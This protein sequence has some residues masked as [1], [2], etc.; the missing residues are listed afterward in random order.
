MQGE[1]T[2]CQEAAPTVEP[3]D[4]HLEAARDAA[5]ME[6]AIL[7][8]ATKLSIAQGATAEDIFSECV[9]QPMLG[10]QTHASK[11]T[12]SGLEWSK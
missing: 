6:T 4:H 8:A 12:H 5:K 7:T 11:T 2:L 9:D 1:C 3:T 10:V